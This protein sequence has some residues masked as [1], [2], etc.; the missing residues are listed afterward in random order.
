MNLATLG[1]VAKVSAARTLAQVTLGRIASGADPLAEL[2]Q[3]RVRENAR[4]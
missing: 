3:Q 1:A 2:A 4:F